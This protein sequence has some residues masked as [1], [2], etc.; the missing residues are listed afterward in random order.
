MSGAGAN[1][2]AFDMKTKTYRRWLVSFLW[3]AVSC[4]LT[5]GSTDSTDSKL[6]RI[7]FYSAEACKWGNSSSTGVR[8]IEGQ[9]VAV[10][11]TVIPYGSTVTIPGLGLFTAVD[12]GTDVRLRTAARKAPGSNPG[13]D[14]AIVIDVFVDR[15]ATLHRIAKT[16][17]HFVEVTWHAPN[18]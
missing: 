2:D 3:L 14:G 1:P 9:H 16:F 5:M 10:D 17:P 11:P 18:S 12:T 13:K 15:E 7:T 6:A 4:S 8:L